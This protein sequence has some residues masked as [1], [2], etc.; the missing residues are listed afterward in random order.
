MV[1]GLMD[2][3]EPLWAEGHIAWGVSERS[4][5]LEDWKP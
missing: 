5:A 1:P 2:R 3:S 4:K